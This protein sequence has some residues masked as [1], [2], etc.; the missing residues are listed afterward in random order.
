VRKRSQSLSQLDEIIV[1]RVLWAKEAASLDELYPKMQRKR[2]FAERILGEMC[3]KGMIEEAQHSYHLAP[4][5]RHDI[6][7]IFQSDQLTLS[8]TM[9]GDPPGGD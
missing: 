3:R 8:P 4:V 5:V 9:W 7:T 2:E 1:L 6:E